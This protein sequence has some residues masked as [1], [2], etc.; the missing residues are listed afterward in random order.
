MKALLLLTVIVSLALFSGCST[1][2]RQ[3]L[4]YIPDTT[5]GSD[6]HQL[7]NRFKVDRIT[8]NRMNRDLD[9]LF[10]TTATDEIERILKDR[11]GAMPTHNTPY[12]IS[13]TLHTLSWE[14]PN[15]NAM[16]R[17]AFTVSMLTGGIG[18]IAYGSTTTPV[19]GN[20]DIEYTVKDSISGITVF[21][22]RYTVKHEEKR[23][24]LSSD[25]PLA[26]AEI[27]S[28]A[29]S[30]SIQMFAQDLSQFYLAV[31]TAPSH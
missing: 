4:S 7:N 19:F 21:T 5:L 29:L 2:P 31:E 24:K 10:E 8:D 14:I 11:F 30:K 22:N 16:V 20:I 17:N 13:G 25:T 26:K 3:S 18:G 15:Y 12:R 27:T 6:P 9:A 23:K 28:Q 1:P